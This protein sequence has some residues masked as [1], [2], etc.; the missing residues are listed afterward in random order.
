MQHMKSYERFVWHF[1]P[2]VVQV[3]RLRWEQR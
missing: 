1:A 3:R 2:V